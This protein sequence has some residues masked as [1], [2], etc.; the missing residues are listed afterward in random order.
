MKS[1]TASSSDR[2]E[3]IKFDVMSAV[4]VLGCA[5]AVLF[6]LGMTGHAANDLFYEGRPGW[7]GT[8]SALVLSLGV[9]GVFA[10]TLVFAGKEHDLKKPN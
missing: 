3:K 6:I 8:S 7:L 2:K 9:A 1:K 10:S 4:I 5:S